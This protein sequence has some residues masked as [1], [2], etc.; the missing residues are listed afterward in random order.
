M[1][2]RA[3]SRAVKSAETP[4]YGFRLA[5]P[6][7]DR[8]IR[9]AHSRGM[10]SLSDLFRNFVQLGYVTDDIDAAASYLESM[11]GTIECVR[12]FKSSLGRATPAPPPG[13]SWWL[14]A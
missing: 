11:F 10:R 4:R 8:L 5:G 9:R 7:L 1:I 6:A 12:H 2:I 14:T 3:P 13:P